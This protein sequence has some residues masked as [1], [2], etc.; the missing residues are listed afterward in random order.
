MCERCSSGPSGLEGHESLNFEPDGQRYGQAKGHH[1]FVCVG[2]GALWTRHYD[3]G[4]I[5]Q[6]RGEQRA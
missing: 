1:L 4:G 5:F 2:C 6:W 3:G